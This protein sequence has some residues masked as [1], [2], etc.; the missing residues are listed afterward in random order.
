VFFLTL[1]AY[2]GGS[3]LEM[4]GKTVKTIWLVSFIKPISLMPSVICFWGSNI[5]NLALHFVSADL[6][7]DSRECFLALNGISIQAEPFHFVLERG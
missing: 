6:E 2:T 1:K 7:K 3:W 4:H 5:T